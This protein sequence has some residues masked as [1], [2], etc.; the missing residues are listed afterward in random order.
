M[1]AFSLMLNVIFVLAAAGC[2][3][4]GGLSSCKVMEQDAQLLAERIVK[5]YLDKPLSETDNRLTLLRDVDQFLDKHRELI[6]SDE[7]EIRNSDGENPMGS[8]EVGARFYQVRK[9]LLLN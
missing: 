8:A 2:G 1:K 3:Q 7:C 4:D 5:L 9:N 6:D